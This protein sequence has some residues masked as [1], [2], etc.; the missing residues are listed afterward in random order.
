MAQGAPA[1][2]AR[3]GLGTEFGE[4]VHSPIHEVSFTRANPGHPSVMLGLRYNDRDGLIARGID[5]DSYY[6]HDHDHDHDGW[7]RG[8]ADPFPVSHRYA[9]PPPGRRR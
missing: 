7:L 4:S 3:P 9:T 1:P 2:S 5:V 8:T 6:G